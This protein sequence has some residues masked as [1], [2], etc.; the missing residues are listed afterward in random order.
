MIDC[1]EVSLTWKNKAS[2]RM[3]ILDLAYIA[4]HRP[5]CD[6]SVLTSVIG[7]SPDCLFETQG[8]N[9]TLSS[10]DDTRRRYSALAPCR[11]R[12]RDV[13]IRRSPLSSS[14]LG[15]RY[16]DH[17]RARLWLEQVIRRITDADI[18]CLGD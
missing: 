15:H 4:P 7:R 12:S 18:S 3:A 6:V 5:N 1:A 13:L 8:G 11:W 17:G 2:T 14:V 9:A 16:L 10:E